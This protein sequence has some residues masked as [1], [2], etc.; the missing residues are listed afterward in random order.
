M[1]NKL[2]TSTTTG[3]DSNRKMEIIGII[4]MSIAILLGLSILSYNSTDYGTVTRVSF[5][6]FFTPDTTSRTIINW[7][8]PVGAYLSHYLVHS[9]FG[10]T[11]IILALIIGYHG[12]H[13]FRRRDF[14]ELGWLTVLSVWGMILLSTFIGWLNT[15]ADFP[16]DSIWSGSAGVAISRVLQNITGMGSI[17]I[18]SVLMIVTLLMF[19]DR[20]L[21]K[22]IDSVKIWMDNLRDKMEDWRAERQLKKE[23]KAKEREERIAAKKA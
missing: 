3:L 12:W 2:N 8:G 7:L 6:D 5:I 17:F 11:S 23:Q 14:K 9:L 13:T 4:V 10:Y 1:A 18:L 19:V 21:Q 20:D 16:S 22:T 15:N